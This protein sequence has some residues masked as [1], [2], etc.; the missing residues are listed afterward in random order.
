MATTRKPKTRSLKVHEI[1][2]E[3]LAQDVMGKN[4]LQGD[5]QLNVHNERQ[6]VPGVKAEADDL[7]ETYEKSDKDVRAKRDLGKGRR[8]SPQHPYNKPETETE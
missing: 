1:G 2:E 3:D 7:M 8:H 6:A 4:T 5:D